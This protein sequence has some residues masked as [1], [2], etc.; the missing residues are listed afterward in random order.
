[1]S[2][3]V[4]LCSH[5]VDFSSLFFLPVAKLVTKS[6]S[7]DITIE[8]VSHFRIKAGKAYGNGLIRIN[9]SH[10]VRVLLY[11]FMQLDLY[12]GE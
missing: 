5:T 1:M 12:P 7:R 11:A 2:C 10:R 4:H 9:Q 6:D 8:P 3:F